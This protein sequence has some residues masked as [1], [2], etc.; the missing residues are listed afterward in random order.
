MF[1]QGANIYYVTPR[2]KWF[3]D[4]KQIFKVQLW[5]LP[6]KIGLGMSKL[7]LSLNWFLQSVFHFTSM[8][9]RGVL[10]I[11]SIPTSNVCFL[12]AGT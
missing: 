8:K 3:L 10:E 5:S 4:G 12:H 11:E 6:L 9:Y 2:Y 1:E 7:G